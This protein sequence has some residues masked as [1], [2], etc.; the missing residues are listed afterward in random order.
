MKRFTQMEEALKERNA[1][2]AG[3]TFVGT[4]AVDGTTYRLALF[5][6]DGGTK[7]SFALKP[8][9]SLADGLKRVD[10]RF[11]GSGS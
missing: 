9:E 4:Q 3:I 1:R 11:K 7:T 10:E 8:G 6:D 5:N 2:L